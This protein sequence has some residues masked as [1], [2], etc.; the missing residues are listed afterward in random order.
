METERAVRSYGFRIIVLLAVLA[1]LILVIA[2]IM[3]MRELQQRVESL[4]PDL[5]SKRDVAMLRPLRIREIL[6]QNC[7]ECHSTRRL[8]TTISMEP[9]EIE[10]TV[11]RMQTHPGANISP[12]D[13]D[14]IAASLLVARC[15]RCHGEESLNLMVL[16]TQPE[17][18]ATIRRMA[19]LPGSGVRADQVL[20]IAQ[21]FDKLIDYRQDGG[22]ANNDTAA[23]VQPRKQ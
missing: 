12:G 6:V 13:F 1:N 20:A 18:I 23:T 7:V 21:A 11:E 14:R 2:L 4:P 22:R 15:A 9:S 17:R 3:Q 8:G 10:R 5:A 19:A 16:K